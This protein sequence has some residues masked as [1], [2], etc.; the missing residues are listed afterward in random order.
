MANLVYGYKDVY[1][2]SAAWGGQA[3]FAVNQDFRP[4]HADLYC[5]CSADWDLTPSWTIKLI[6]PFPIRRIVI[7]NRANGYGKV[8]TFPLCFYT[9]IPYTPN[10]FLNYRFT[11]QQYISDLVS[12]STGV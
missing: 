2:S 6:Q 5:Q 10:R 4:I 12:V 3:E 9:V 7:T 8:I 1:D 11:F